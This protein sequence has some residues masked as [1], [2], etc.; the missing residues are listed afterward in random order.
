M[1]SIIH[2][3]DTLKNKAFLYLAWVISALIL[4][5]VIASTDV[6]VTAIVW[7]NNHAPVILSV[8]PSDDPRIL[9]T[10]KVQKYIIYFKDDEKNNSTFTVTPTYWYV[11]PISWSI[12][13]Y[14]SLSWAYIN[15]TYIAPSTVPTWNLDD[16]TVTINDWIWWNII[17]KKLNI[18]VY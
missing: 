18:H 17:T 16:I 4:T 12:S 5:V 10:N 9:R 11:N 7:N 15:F 6:L 13:S 3:K 1:N 2:I 8:N 14:D